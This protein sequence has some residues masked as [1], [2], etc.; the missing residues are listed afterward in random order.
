MYLRTNSYR[1]Q[2]AIIETIVKMDKEYSKCIQRYIHSIFDFTQIKTIY[3]SRTATCHTDNAVWTPLCSLHH[4]SFFSTPSAAF[5]L[6]L[7]IIM[8]IPFHYINS[9][10]IT[11]AITESIKNIIKRDRPRKKSIAHRSLPIRDDVSNPAFPSG[12][13]AQ[14]CLYHLDKQ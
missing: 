5:G 1:K 7:R 8:V 11:V 6:L 3:K 2:N 10:L 4:C 13:S 12:D 14:V 9:S